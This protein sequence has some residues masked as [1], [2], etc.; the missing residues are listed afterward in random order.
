MKLNEDLDD[1]TSHWQ[2]TANKLAQVYGSS[3]NIGGKHKRHVTH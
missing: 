3:E 2:K 1:C